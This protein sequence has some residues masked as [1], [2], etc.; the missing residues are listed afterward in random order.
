MQK[1]FITQP[2]LFATSADLE[3]ACLQGLEKPLGF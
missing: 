3:H 1:P 2:A